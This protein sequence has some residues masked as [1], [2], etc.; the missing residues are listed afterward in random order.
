MNFRKFWAIR[1]KQQGY[2]LFEVI[3]VLAITG[4]IG[5][6]VSMATVQVVNQGTRNND[7]NTATRHALNTVHWVSRD[8][9]MSQTLEPTGSS[10]FPLN[11]SWVDWDNSTHLVTY[12]E[13]GDGLRRSY[14]ID[15][16][17]PTE[18]VVG[19]YINW[20]SEN[21]TCDFSDGMLS[22]KVTAIVGTGE[23]AV[24][25]TRIREITPRPGL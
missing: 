18:T 13:E 8:A 9:Q 1:E 16:G 4:F 2:S 7:Y 21:T 3:V 6:G 22:L 10:G 19:Q 25:V 23:N 11:L 5:I 12:T 20:E 17:E 15:G 24:S 14:S